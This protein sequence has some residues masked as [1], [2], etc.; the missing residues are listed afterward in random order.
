VI[1]IVPLMSQVA[2]QAT[3]TN[4]PGPWSRSAMP[5]AIRGAT[6]GGTS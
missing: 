3:R 6:G 5:A 2:E 1:L 4:A